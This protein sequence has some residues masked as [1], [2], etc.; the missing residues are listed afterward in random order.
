[1]A[2]AATR[3][4]L[5]YLIIR[6]K[7]EKER[8]MKGLALEGIMLVSI[9]LSDSTY[10]VSQLQC[11]T[12]IAAAGSFCSKIPNDQIWK[13]M[14]GM[15]AELSVPWTRPLMEGGCSHELLDSASLQLTFK[16]HERPGVLMMDCL[17]VKQFIHKTSM[18]HPKIRFHYCV[19]M[20][21]IMSAETYCGDKRESTCVLNGIKLLTD[22][23]HY[24]RV[25]DS[26]V[27]CGS[28]FLCD[29]IHPV[30][31]RTV[32]LLIPHEVAETGF[33]GELE[34]IPAAALCPCLKL[35]PNQPAKIAAVSIF[36][37]D[38]TG[39]PISFYGKG[40]SSLFFSDP[41]NLAEWEKYN[42]S[43]TLDSDPG[44]EEDQVSPDVRYKLHWDRGSQEDDPDT[45]EQTLLL[46][47]F[48]H[49]SDQFQDKPSYDFWARRMIA[50]H[51]DQILLCSQQAVKRG[52][53]AVI[54]TVLEEHCKRRKNQQRLKLSLPVILGA[55]SNVVSSSTNSQFRRECLQ[56]LQVADT[57]ELMA[58]IQTAFENVTQ[59]RLMPSGT[60]NITKQ[61]PEDANPAQLAACDLPT[62]GQKPS[63]EEV[64]DSISSVD[65]EPAFLLGKAD[66][67]EEMSETKRRKTANMENNASGAPEQEPPGGSQEGTDNLMTDF[68]SQLCSCLWCP[69]DG[70]DA[71]MFL[72]ERKEGYTAVSLSE[73]RSNE[74]MWQSDQLWLQEIS[75]LSEWTS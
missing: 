69:K 48:L 63:Q 5:E 18:V 60:C 74:N 32:N 13:E 11:I 35:F 1:M 10:G 2:A 15:L 53:Q 16:L 40:K 42:Y 56:S 73:G 20:N 49:Y 67:W 51:L 28:N 14:D 29:K 61:V 62:A 36:F 25:V 43:A 68:G 55:I 30:L 57:S 70:A 75:N 38:P 47:L 9:N 12:T 27:S 64:S 23:R 26:L 22:R 72:G 59:K 41:S 66:L 58:A 6:F 54:D 3:T 37:Y 45:W 50:S 65:S 71:S 34:F 4:I 17:A 24:I 19:N 7:S 52:A 39:L 31:G 21:G 8:Q 44:Q 46:F 33:T